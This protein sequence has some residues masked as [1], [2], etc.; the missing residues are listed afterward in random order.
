MKQF[1]ENTRVEIET[2][3][4]EI[5]ELEGKIAEMKKTRKTMT[6]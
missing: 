4:K 5:A 3:D 2:I 6:T 1:R